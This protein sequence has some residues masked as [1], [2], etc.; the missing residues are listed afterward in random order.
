MSLRADG[1]ASGFCRVV[2]LMIT[3]KSIEDTRRSSKSC[4]TQIKPKEA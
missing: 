1:T 3:Y 4:D 2:V